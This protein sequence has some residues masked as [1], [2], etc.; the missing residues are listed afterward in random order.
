MPSSSPW[1]S[2]RASERTSLQERDASI[3][4][5][6]ISARSTSSGNA[7]R[8]ADDELDAGQDRFR[9]LGLELDLGAVQRLLQDVLKPAPDLGV[10]ALARHVDEAGDEAREGVAAQEQAERLALVQVQDL[11]HD[12]EQLVV[13]GLQQ[14]VARIGLEDVDQRLARVAGGRQ[15]GALDQPRDLVP[16]QRDLARIA[17]VGGR[18]EQAEEAVLAQDLALG[19]EPADAEVV[20]IDRPVHGRAGV[21]LG[22]HQRHRGARLAAQLRRQCCEAARGGAAGRLAPE[23]AERRALEALQLIARLIADQVVAAVA[24]QGE[25]VVGDPAQERLG[26]GQ[27]GRLEHL[28]AGLQVGDRDLD[29]GQHRA[30]V[31]DRRPDIGKRLLEVDPDRLDPL[32]IALPVDLEMH[33]GFEAGVAAV[34]RGRLQHRLERARGRALDRHDRVDRDVDQEAQPVERHAHRID[35]ERHVV[36]DHLDHGVGRLPA[37][38]L[39]LGVVDPDQRLAGQALLAEAEMGERGAIDVQRVALEQIDGRDR[40]VVVADEGFGPLRLAVGELVVQ[41]IDHPLEQIRL[42]VLQPG[43][44]GRPPFRRPLSPVFK[45]RARRSYRP[46]LNQG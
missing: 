20:E 21:G 44:H 6:S 10:V 40:P 45:H 4:R 3:R 28:G 33:V 15:A 46:I 31:L 8:G 9:D 7:V 34:G 14:L 27:L 29:L 16:E 22:D 17:I 43:C 25:V 11:L 24:E 42:L 19:V 39:D 38:L 32:G 12:L 41:L 37:V 2:I 5:A 26:L 30:P 36:G 35:Q 18:G 23:Q 13:A 1:A